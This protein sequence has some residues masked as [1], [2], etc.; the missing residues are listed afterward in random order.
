MVKKKQLHIVI[1]IVFEAD[2]K[3]YYGRTTSHIRIRYNELAAIAI[4]DIY[5]YNTTCKSKTTVHT[6]LQLELML[7][8]FR[9]LLIPVVLHTVRRRLWCRFWLHQSSF[10][11]RHCR[12]VGFGVHACTCTT[13]GQS[14]IFFCE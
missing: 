11:A 13:C 14:G 3:A 5:I 1:Q 12:G 7:H 10:N 4:D 9:Y 6:P 2:H 8:S